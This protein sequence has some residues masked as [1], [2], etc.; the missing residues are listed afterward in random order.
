MVPWG[1]LVCW[2]AFTDEDPGLW[3]QVVSFLLGLFGAVRIPVK[4][5]WR[6]TADRTGLWLNGLRG[7]THIPWDDIRSVRRE[8]LELKLRWRGDGSWAVAA[9]RWAWFQ[10]VSGVTHPYDAL[11]AEVTAMHADPALR[12]TGDS[13]ERERGRPLWPLAV[14]FVLAWL[15]AVLVALVGFPDR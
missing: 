3:R 12:P 4:L 13:E 2:A 8:S 11:A 10:R 15:T 9:P 1:F 14:P 6:I 7:T 5:C